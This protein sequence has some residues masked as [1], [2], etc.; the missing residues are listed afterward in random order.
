VGASE[1]FAVR[2]RRSGVAAI[3]GTKEREQMISLLV[4]EINYDRNSEME[5]FDCDLI[6]RGWRALLVAL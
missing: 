1:Y 5:L 3:N 2:A 6:D 4:L